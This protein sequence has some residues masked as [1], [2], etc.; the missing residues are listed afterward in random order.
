MKESLC[1]LCDTPVPIGGQE[2]CCHGCHTVYNILSARQMLDRFQ[3]SSVFQQ[4][5]KT[6]LISNP[7]LL[8]RIR[9]CQIELSKE[10]SEK[11]YFEVSDMWCPSCAEIIRLVLSQNKGIKNCIVDYATDM[12]VVDFAPKYISKEK[13]LNEVNALGYK[14]YFLDDV[15]AK[16]NSLD[17]YIRFGVAAF[18]ASNAMMFSYPLY[19]TY[20]DKHAET[21]GHLFALLTGL[22]SIPVVTYCMKPIYTR[23]FNSLRFGLVGMEALVVGVFSAFFLSVY[24]LL[25]GSNHVYFD[26]MTVIVAFILLGKLI[27]SKAKFSSKDSLIKLAKS[28]P[29]RAR[30]AET[31]NSPS[32]FVPIKEIKMDEILSVYTGE[33]IA[34]D[35]IVVDGQGSCDESLMTGESIP[36][37]K[38]NGSKLIGGSILKEGIINYRVTQVAGDTTLDKIVHLVEEDISHKTLYER[39][40]DKI[41]YWF[42]PLIIFIALLTAFVGWFIGDDQA[43]IN[44]VS[45][46]LIACPCALG[47]AAPLA[48]AKMLQELTTKGAIV[49]NRGVLAI[50]P[51]ITQFVFDKTGTITHGQFILISGVD[52][53]SEQQKKILKGLSQKSI[54]SI[55]RAIFNSLDVE[56]EILDSIEE[57]PGKGMRGVYK[58]KKIFLG[59]SHFL[60]EE[61]LKIN[62]EE[63]PSDEV[64]SKVYFSFGEDK[65]YTLILGDKIREEVSSLIPNLAQKTLLLSGDSKITVETIAK[66]A[67]FKEFI[68]SSSPFKKREIVEGLRQKGEI[69]CMIGDGINDA[70]ALTAAQIGISV[71]SASDISIQVSDILL[72]T[73]NLKILPEIQKIA[74][75]GQQIIKQNLFWAFF[76]NVCGILL[77]VCGLLTPIFAAFA[78]VVSSLIVLFNSKRL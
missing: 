53:L 37:F 61:G 54:H 50:L 52:S 45:V 20:F 23:F 22:A 73:E 69:V 46:L 7:E 65:V 21:D 44:A 8:E 33:K 60:Q 41:V 70:P 66:K 71:L 17:L 6:G 76:Y 15:S 63:E 58:G 77:A 72:T 27:E 11:I 48:E 78:M 62:L 38:K 40:A 74:R 31:A 25:Q 56:I 12:A 3:S 30:R 19:A 28:L 67:G 55:S 4:A 57:L 10:E 43:W 5:V 64:H 18:F 59:S 13:I 9:K 24:Q 75:K 42:T 51:K 47:I 32:E 35:G 14:A 16:K 36:V 68:Y 39:A 1:L 2:F 26:S 34:L 49:R 29:K